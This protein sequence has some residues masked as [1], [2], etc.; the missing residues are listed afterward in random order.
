MERKTMASII[1]K[2]T[3]I[4]KK[5]FI[6]AAT[7]IVE[8]NDGQ[9]DGVVLVERTHH[10]YGWCF[11]GGLQEFGESLATCAKRELEE[12]T[13]L[14]IVIYNP[15]TPLVVQSDPERDPRKFFGYVS[16]N[17]YIGRGTGILRAGDDAKNTKVVTMEELEAHIAEGMP[18]DHADSAKEYLTRRKSLEDQLRGYVTGRLSAKMPKYAFASQLELDVYRQ[19]LCISTYIS[20]E[21]EQ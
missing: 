10:P 1:S 3:D 15:R 12:E 20:L 14:N 21:G 7:V 9:K 6:P 11:P 4:R 16:D 19:R 17:I 8:Y 2:P 18:F 13:N 5:E